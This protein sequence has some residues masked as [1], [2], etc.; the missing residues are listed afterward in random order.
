MMFFYYQKQMINIC[1]PGKFLNKNNEVPSTKNCNSS[2]SVWMVLN[3][4]KVNFQENYMNSF[5]NSLN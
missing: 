5:T 2:S 4:D 3:A 1:F